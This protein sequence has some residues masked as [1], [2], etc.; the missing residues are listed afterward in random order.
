MKV[1][2][3]GCGRVGATLA[4]MLYNEGHDV[5][6][7]DQSPE[8]F[9]RLGAGFPEAS[10]VLGNGTDEDVLIRAGIETADTFVA[11]TNGDNRNI[12]AVQIAKYIFNVPRT[13]CRIYDPIRQE[14]YNALGLESICPTVIS[15]KLFR[16]ALLTPITRSSSVTHSVAQ[17]RS[18]PLTPIERDRAASRQ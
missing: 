4:Q 8:A 3:L 14:T 13:M 17:G 12:L 5:S 16:D 9:R 10:T 18:V 15:A 1:V 2:I 11:V 6:I 7:I